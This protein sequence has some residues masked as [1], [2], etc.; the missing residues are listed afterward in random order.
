M[1]KTMV[2]KVTDDQFASCS[3]YATLRGLNPYKT[4]NELLN[5]KIRAR[6]GEN[7]RFDKQPSFMRMGDVLENTVLDEACL[8]LNLTNVRL[9][10]DK[11]LIHDTLP[12][13]G[14]P[15]GI[16]SIDLHESV[17]VRTD[18]DNCIFT[19][20]DKILRLKGDGILECK[21]TSA[22][23]E[24]VLPAWRGVYQVLA[25]MECANLTWGAVVVLYQ[26]VHLKIFIFERDENWVKEFESAVIDFER[27][28][29]EEDYYDVENSIDCNIVYPQDV[30]DTV[31]ID[32]SLEHHF[33]EIK[34]GKNLIKNTQQTIQDHETII[35]AHMQ[36]NK[37]A[38]CGS[39]TATWGSRTFKAT[40]EKI[41]P[42][43]EARTVR[44]KTL[45]IKEVEN[46][47][48]D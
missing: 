12:I 14:S 26:S 39:H 5:E 20:N 22:F 48:L 15:D 30:E 33:S 17:A 35:K 6:A 23:P 27:R 4:R 28:I 21:I 41:V 3:G 47:G 11:P 19:P 36:E 2:G 24:D 29:Q 32:S 9:N 13:Q 16:A 40:D 43:K 8:R 46:Y 44:S 25:N 42:A 37:Y 34:A 31:E 38:L 18:Q 45:Q 1:V 10:I 7:V